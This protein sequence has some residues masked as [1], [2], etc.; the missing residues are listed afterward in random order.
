M[1]RG[2]AAIATEMLGRGEIDAMLGLGGSGGSSV[3]AA[4]AHVLPVG[5]PKL[6]V[7]TM[8][9]GDV[10]AYVGETDLTLMYSV[11]DIAGINVISREILRNAAAGDRRDGAGLPR[12]RAVPPR[13][14]DGT[15]GSTARWWQR[16]CSG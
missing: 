2:A 16:R 8:V 14:A 15:A 6:L 1:G 13:T 12:A 4:V 11:V 5:L 7:S 10:S 9:S 3:V